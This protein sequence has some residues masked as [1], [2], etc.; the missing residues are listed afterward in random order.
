MSDKLLGIG[1]V[2]TVLT[3]ICCFTPFLPIL[4]TAL[5]LGSLLG[6]LYNDAVLLPLLG[7]F[8]LTTGYALWRRHKRLR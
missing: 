2:G 7:V 1:L 4:L 8:M 5:G 3:A 6:L